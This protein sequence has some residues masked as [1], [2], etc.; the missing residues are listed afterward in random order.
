[1]SYEANLPD[2]I[3]VAKFELNPYIEGDDGVRVS[4]QPYPPSK[5][6]VAYARLD[7]IPDEIDIYRAIKRSGARKHGDIARAIHGAI[8]DALSQ[9]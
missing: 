4:L 1:M 9:G 8:V 6:W 5:S 3:I 2:R 7:A